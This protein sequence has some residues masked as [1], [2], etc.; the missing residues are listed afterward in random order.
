MKNIISI[1]MKRDGDTYEEAKGRVLDVVDMMGDCDYDPVE[2]EDI[3][4]NFLGLEI[5]YLP[6]LLYNDL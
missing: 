3:F 2:C 5:D 4:I 6:D 1:L